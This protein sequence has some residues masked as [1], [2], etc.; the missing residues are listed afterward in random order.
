MR[1]LLTLIFLCLLITSAAFSKPLSDYYPQESVGLVVL[2][3]EDAKYLFDLTGEE[4]ETG[5]VTKEV[6][7]ALKD[8]FA[9][10]LE[11]D[12]EQV[13]LFFV[14]TNENAAKQFNM[15]GGPMDNP[16]YEPV[17]FLCGEFDSKTI[18]PALK[19]LV[20]EASKDAPKIETISIGD[21]K[22]LTFSANDN[23]LI[24]FKKNMLFLCKDTAV[25]L[26][27]NNKLTFAKAP[28][29][30]E[31]LQERSKSFFELKKPITNFL[32]AMA[33]PIDGLETLD[34]LSGY[35]T[36]DFLYAEGGFRDEAA[37]KSMLNNIEKFKNDFYAE[38]TKN[39]EAAKSEIYTVSFEQLFED[40]N[41]MYNAA[42]N[43]DIVDHL[44]I[45]QK[46]SSI[47]IA[48]PY[49]KDDKL[50][51]AVGGIGVIAAM[52][53]PNFKAARGSAREKA[54]FSNQRVLLGA[55]EMYNMDHDEM[56]TKLDIP[57]LVKEKYLKSVPTG[58]EPECEYF[59]IGDLSKDGT[60]GCKRH[61]GVPMN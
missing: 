54:C 6:L 12:V 34:S 27:Q 13:G 58:P 55:V 3:I 60:I 31:G 57:T 24:F 46:G 25:K 42:K 22:V 1:K 32:T 43:K 7:S 28:S 30:F 48:Q 4:T 14:P 16:G 26:M 61:G 40:I 45:S 9:I 2:G 39:Y 5:K 59:S 33:L 17:L 19:K 47:I 53:V 35:L 29:S 15:P 56:M 44:K 18:I 51:M 10:D 38:Q 49:D 37:A 11:K 36:K 8:K 41:K 23:R 21:K 52:A 20:S 50:V